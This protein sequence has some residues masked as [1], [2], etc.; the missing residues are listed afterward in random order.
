MGS[1]PFNEVSTSG[2]TNESNNEG[3][4]G[5]EQFLGFHGQLVSYP[6]GSDAFREFYKAK[7]AVGGKWGKY[8]ELVGM[9]SIVERKESL[10]GKIAEEETELKLILEELGLSRK[11]R[12]DSRSNNVR[13]AQ[14]ISS[15]A[16][17]D[18]GKR[19]EDTS[20]M[21]ACLIK[22]MWLG[23]EEE[24]SELKKAKRKLEKDLARVKTEAMKEVRQLKASHVVAIGQLQVVAKAN[25]HEIVEEL[26]RLGPHLILKGYSEDELDA[27]KADTY[28]EVEDEEAEVI[29]P[30]KACLT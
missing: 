6:P 13:K 2:R 7:E 26:D 19:G 23:I 14:S 27:I 5:L 15:M 22:G 20:K 3:E 17:V 30:F 11:K 10:L 21:V 9:K 25:L 8:V 24:K 12:V 29:G 28:V 18:E 1:S 16:G 4:E